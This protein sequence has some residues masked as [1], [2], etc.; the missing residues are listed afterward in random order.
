[1]RVGIPS[2]DKK[3]RS[4]VITADLYCSPYAML[5]RAR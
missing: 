5:S 2:R 3:K 1:M 4:A